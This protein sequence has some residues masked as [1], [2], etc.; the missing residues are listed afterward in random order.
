MAEPQ[1]KRAENWKAIAE[2]AQ[3]GNKDLEARVKR[4]QEENAGLVDL[5]YMMDKEQS[6]QISHAVTAAKVTGHCCLFFA[7]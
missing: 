7:V 1:R 6:L 2:T 4:H 5:M 3:Q